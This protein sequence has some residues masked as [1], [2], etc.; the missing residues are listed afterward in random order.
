MRPDS[1][2]DANTRKIR[3]FYNL[4]IISDLYLNDI[5]LHCD[6]AHFGLRNGLFQ[7]PKSTISHPK[8]G[9]IA[10]RNG[11][12]RKAESII[13]DYDIGYIKGLYGARQ[14]SYWSI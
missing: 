6:I 5:A 3:G 1:P 10:P 11:Q 9:F 7:R 14:A 8:M 13:P 4:L 2:S 12:Y